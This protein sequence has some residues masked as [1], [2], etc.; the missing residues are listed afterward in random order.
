MLITNEDNMEQKNKNRTTQSTIKNV[1]KK[2]R[3]K[4]KLKV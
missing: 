1:L 2:K 4:K 3:W